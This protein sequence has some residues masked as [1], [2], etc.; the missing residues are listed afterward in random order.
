MTR[1]VLGSLIVASIGVRGS[2]AVVDVAVFRGLV[3]L[4]LDYAGLSEQAA[5][6]LTGER[7]VG[8]LT[9]DLFSP[10]LRDELEAALAW[11]CDAAKAGG[12]SA[13][14]GGDVAAPDRMVEG[15]QAVA[16]LFQQG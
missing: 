15:G 3:D 12:R 4:M 5:R 8:S 16:A 10:P 9:V 7:D 6:L 1:A 13:R 14:S 11:A 2:D